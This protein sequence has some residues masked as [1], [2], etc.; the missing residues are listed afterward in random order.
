MRYASAYRRKNSSRWWIHYRECGG[1]R[2]ARS[3]KNAAGYDEAL[4]LAEEITRRTLGADERHDDADIRWLV[5][6]RIL[7]ERGALELYGFRRRRDPDAGPD[8]LAAAEEH[9]S[10]KKEERHDVKSFT[11]HKRETEEFIE[12][13]GSER[14]T[15]VTTERVEAWIE[16][17]RRKGSKPDGIRHR[18][19]WLR[20]A[21]EI[22]ANRHGLPNELSE[23]A[24]EPSTR[25]MIET[26]TTKEMVQIA[27]YFCV[28]EMRKH[29]VA[30]ALQGFV[31]LRPSEMTRLWVRD[32]DSRGYLQVGARVTKEGTPRRKNKFAFRLLPLPATVA[33][34]AKELAGNRPK[35]EALV[36]A[37]RRGNDYNREMD[38]TTTSRWLSRH[39]AAAGVERRLRSKDLRKSFATAAARE[40]KLRPEWIEAYL[41]RRLT[42]F[43]TV[44]QDHYLLEFSA[45]ELLPAARKIGRWVH[46]QVHSEKKT[47]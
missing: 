2:E 29:L 32:L 46:F 6:N 36:L 28:H 45:R 34:W 26:Y 35:D 5:E 9:R 27:R 17:L 42:Q 41:G 33:T 1:K 21:G 12:W 20:R 14:L 19:I 30:F 4:A 24:V 16:R 18:L 3:A 38:E 7:T 15:D 11:R 25:P 22:G 31:G 10:T 23:I 43:S 44:T 8:I 39:F 37:D 13:L 40:W 47:A